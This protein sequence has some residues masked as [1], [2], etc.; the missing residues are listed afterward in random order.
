[1]SFN[2]ENLNPAIL[3][4]AKAVFFFPAAPVKFQRNEFQLTPGVFVPKKPFRR[5]KELLVPTGVSALQER[6][7]LQRDPSAALT[8]APILPALEHC[9]ACDREGGLDR[10]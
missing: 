1:M 7:V 3:L 6:Q 10:S 4:F 8:S 5:H 9:G 2:V